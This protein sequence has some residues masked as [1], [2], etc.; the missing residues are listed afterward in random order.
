MNGSESPMAMKFISEIRPDKLAMS[1]FA[2]SYFRAHCLSP[3]VLGAP[4]AEV[5]IETP[6]WGSQAFLPTFVARTKVGRGAGA[7]SPNSKNK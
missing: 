5:R 4:R 2:R 3:R 7:E 6:V 1:T